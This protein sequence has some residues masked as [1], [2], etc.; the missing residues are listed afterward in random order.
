[1][2]RARTAVAA[3]ALLGGCAPP[4]PALP[5]PRAEGGRTAFTITND[6]SS[7]YRIDKVLLVVDG[8][9]ILNGELAEGERARLDLGLPAGDHTLQILVKASYPSG[10]IDER[11]AVEI[12]AMRPFHVEGSGGEVAA[13]IETGAITVGFSDRVDLS[14]D[15]HGVT[16][17]DPADFTP[18]P[19][20][21]EEACSRLGPVRGAA[22]TGEILLAEAER[23]RDGIK[24]LCYQ[25]KMSALR[26][27]ARAFGAT[28]AELA[29]PGGVNR[30]SPARK[31]DLA[32]I[33]KSAVAIRDAM[34]SCVSGGG[35]PLP[36]LSRT[37]VGEHCT[38][39]D[40]FGDGTL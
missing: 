39:T 2:M 31:A 21:E 37:V 26:S 20:P 13:R 18:V 36:E 6:A 4:T 30:V 17:V 35:E 34:E 12:R 22:C 27:Y 3:F 19:S 28:E 7:L 8:S 25:D 32:A 29:E 23:S 16:T 40:P 33:T 24:T 11:C 38:G 9:V 14:F 15:L 10:S 5:P 1:M